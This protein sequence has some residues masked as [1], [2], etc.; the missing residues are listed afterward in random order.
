MTIAPITTLTTIQ[1][2]AAEPLLE[3]IGPLRLR[4]CPLEPAPRQEAFLRLRA[5][6]ALF[7]GAAGGGKS[8]ALLMAAL[9]YA[10]VPGYHALLLR[11]SLTEFELP[12]GLIEL[13]HEWLANTKAEWSGETRSWRFPGPGR[14]GAGGATLRFG[15]LEGQKDVARYQ[16]ASFSFLGFDEL[17]RKIGRAS[18]RERM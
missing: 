9:Q 2:E 11:P 17:T 14:S 6:E 16:G 7:G 8:I 3:L 10:D 12:G 1:Q 15:Y 5:L 13:A 18:C 4:Y